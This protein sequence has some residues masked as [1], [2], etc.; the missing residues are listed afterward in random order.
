MAVHRNT[1]DSAHY[2]T[3]D[4]GMAVPRR[5]MTVGRNIAYSSAADHCSAELVFAPEVL[6]C[7]S[8]EECILCWYPDCL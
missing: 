2:M 8:H 6:Y 7:V 1:A 3:A 4:R 5:Y